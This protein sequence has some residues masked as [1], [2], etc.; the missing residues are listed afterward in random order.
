MPYFEIAVSD[1][2]TQ[3]CLSLSFV[4]NYL[5]NYLIFISNYFWHKACYLVIVVR[6]LFR[7][8]KDILISDENMNG[9][10]RRDLLRLVLEIVR[11]CCLLKLGVD[12]G[13]GLTQG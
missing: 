2:F 1:F 4:G 10:I 3:F 7:A 12:L 5:S 8:S 6:G 9:C 13:L 11:N